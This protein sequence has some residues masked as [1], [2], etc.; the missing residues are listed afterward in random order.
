MTNR[1]STR[2]SKDG[3]TVV[4]LRGSPAE[5]GEAHGRLLKNEIQSCYEEFI[6]RRVLS[7]IAQELFGDDESKIADFTDWAYAQAEHYVDRIR[8]AFVEEM[9][10]LAHAAGLSWRQVLLGQV[11]L[12]VVEFAGMAH[13]DQFF[14]SCTQAA[15]LPAVTG[16]ATQ[17][18]RS[19][20]WPPYGMAHKVMAL[21]HFMPDDGIAFWSPG[22]VGNIGTLTAYNHAGLVV[23]EES[24]TE[25]TDVS[26]QGVPQ[27]LLHRE[28][29]QFHDDLDDA[30]R[31]LIGSP[32]NNGYHTLL[33]DANRGDALTVLTSA[34]HHTLRGPRDGV[35]WGVEIDRQPERY[36]DGAM[37]HPD[38][39]LSNRGSD[40]RYAR[41]KQLVDG[42]DGDVN[43]DKLMTWLAD[44]LDITTGK[45]GTSL[46]CLA[47][48]TTLQ[49][50]VADTARREFFVAMGQVPAS[51]G[52]F[53]RFSLNE[54]P[55]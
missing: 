49:C 9:Q 15:F 28:L 21:F 27:F 45:P 41:L 6:E 5:M 30:A 44:D 4:E 39:P 52:G 46:N 55:Q 10:A 23:T 37:P 42:R 40:V 3:I 19:L 11:L 50:F 12:D 13:T 43:A 20:D 25:T 22:F 38:V 48:E 24:L 2:W 53:V 18:A 31:Y 36:R 54:Q 16:G 34:H 7:G 51:A 35:C 29:A 32:R 17:V 1:S 14:H 47:N 8:P 33:S 26:D